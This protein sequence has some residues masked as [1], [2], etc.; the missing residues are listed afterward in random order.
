M[1]YKITITLE[2]KENPFPTEEIRLAAVQELRDE[3]P[4]FVTEC[5]LAVEEIPDEDIP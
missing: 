1:P 2:A 4:G 5:S 3:F